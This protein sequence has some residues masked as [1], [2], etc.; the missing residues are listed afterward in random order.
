MIRNLLAGI[1]CLTVVIMLVIT[2]WFYRED[3]ERWWSGRAGVAV[4]EPS[5]E[6]AERAEEKIRELAEGEGDDEVRLSA[7]ELQSWVRYRLAEGLPQ[8]VYN[9]T[10]GLKDSTL[11]MSAE[12]DLNRLAASSQAAEGL[13]RF[14]GDS[15]RVVIELQPSV[16]GPGEG[17][18][19][20]LSLQ[21]GMVPV[22][23]PF[24]PFVLRQAGLRT[25]ASGRRVLFALPRDVDG[26][27]VQGDELVITRSPNGHP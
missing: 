19:A 26:I 21:A 17:S 6:L 15:A 1:G 20:V 14:M 13:R 9:P 10:L 18:V 8:G 12:L 3:I 16:N 5:P 2:A 24:I 11:E 23:P 4:T 7:L 25:D 27:A 22:P